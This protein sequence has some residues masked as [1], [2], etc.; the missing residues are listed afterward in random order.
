MP[1]PLLHQTFFTP[2][3]S[4]HYVVIDILWILYPKHLWKI[5]CLMAIYYLVS[6]ISWH[7]FFTSPR[8]YHTN[9][10]ALYQ[11]TENL[12]CVTEDKPQQN[13]AKGFRISG[14]IRVHF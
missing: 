9:I 6:K 3:R 2:L 5:Q 14:N 13:I 11:K 1:Y 10:M 8:V 4:R 12:I 7:F